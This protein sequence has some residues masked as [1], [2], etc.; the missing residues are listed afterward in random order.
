MKKLK[1]LMRYYK[2]RK[3]GKYIVKKHLA[4]KFDENWQEYFYYIYTIEEA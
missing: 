4:H 3:I 1:Q 2:Q